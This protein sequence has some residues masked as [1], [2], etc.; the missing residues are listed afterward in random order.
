MYEMRLRRFYETE[1]SEQKGA[2]TKS[3]ARPGTLTVALDEKGS[4]WNT[5]ELAARIQ[6]WTDDP[7]V[8]NVRF[9]V[10]YAHGLSK[11][12]RDSAD[13]TWALSPLTLQG[14]LAWLLLWEQVYRAVT[15]NKGIPYH[16]E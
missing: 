5:L 15:I 12:V 2:G 16:H 4:P 1:S 8:K 13:F 14:D 9:V 3:A 11:D 7:R 10:G 6:R